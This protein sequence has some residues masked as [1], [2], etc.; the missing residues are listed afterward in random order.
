MLATKTD[1]VRE[2][3]LWA[4]QAKPYTQWILSDYDTW[5]PNPY[6]VGPDSGHP[7][8]DEPPTCAV[9]GTFAAASTA[10]REYAVGLGRALRL[11]H[12]KERCW[13]VWF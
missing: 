4:G 6:Y 5:A 2:Y 13:V 1:A 9:F 11:E 12:Y 7:E 8:N 10:A 3:A